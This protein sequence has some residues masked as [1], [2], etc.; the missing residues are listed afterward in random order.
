MNR[1]SYDPRRNSARTLEEVARWQGADTEAVLEPDLPI[2]D[3]HHH[4]FRRDRN[5][6][7][8][9]DLLS[10]L[11]SGHN[12][13][14]T[15]FM[16]GHTGYRTTGPEELHPVG[17][18]EY[19][20]EAIQTNTTGR[21]ICA[22]IVAYADLMLGN[23]VV[24]LL[25]AQIEAGQGRLR[26]IRHAIRWD[27]AGIGLFGHDDPPH[28]AANPSFRQGFSHLASHRLSFDAWLFYHQIE[29]FIELVEMFPDTP[30]IVNHIGGPLG[31][32]PY[33]GWRSEVH[34]RW[35]RG[36]ARLAQYPNVWMK[37]GGC[38]MLYYGFD[39]YKQPTPP[40]SEQLAAAWKPYINHCIE[41]FGVDR[42][43]LESNFPVDKQ[44][45]SYRVLWNT[46]K[47][48]TC[49]FTAAEKTALYSG[50]ATEAYRL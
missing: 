25:E 50:T 6:Y 21:N 40:S 15:V 17:E 46:F 19:A 39:F 29:E 20:L 4:L 3:P 22:G 47:L 8:I 32:G 2:I 38:G 31:V 36:I 26:G 33:A 1:P 43:M 23:R 18:T 34:D 9:P 28:L 30:I 10:D 7:L 24:P 27:A 5:G 41:Q 42:C 12:V 11:G 13:V 45:C 48:L 35:R 49:D 44:T 16:E 37:V 14:A